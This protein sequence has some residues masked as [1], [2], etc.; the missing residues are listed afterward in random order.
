ML[1]QRRTEEFE[2]GSKL[3]LGK[4]KAFLRQWASAG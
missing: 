2:V 1:K 3:D 4:V